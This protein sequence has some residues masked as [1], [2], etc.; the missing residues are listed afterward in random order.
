LLS[1]E[2][3]VLLLLLLSSADAHTSLRAWSPASDAS[4]SQTSTR[5]ALWYMPGMSRTCCSL[6]A[7][8]SWLMQMASTQS[9]RARC[10]S[11]SC[12]SAA[13]RFAVTGKEHPPL[14]NTEWGFAGLPHS[15]DRASYR[16]G[17]SPVSPRG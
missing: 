16:D 10:R 3:S 7:R 8:S 2:D 11:R 15:Y 12:D 14:T 6:S 17:P 1:G 9:V 13:W 4:P 5:L